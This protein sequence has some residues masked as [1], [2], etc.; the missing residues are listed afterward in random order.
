MSRSC[1][2]LDQLGPSRPAGAIAAC[3]RSG[4]MRGSHERS[5][6]FRC[7]LAYP[8]PR[9]FP[10]SDDAVLGA[11]NLLEALGSQCS[12][13]TVFAGNAGNWTTHR[14]GSRLRLCGWRRRGG[15][16]SCRG[17]SPLS[18]LS[19]AP[20]W[21]DF[22]DD[23]YAGGVRPEV[24]VLATAIV[25]QARHEEVKTIVWPL[26]ILDSDHERVAAASAPRSLG[27]S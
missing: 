22:L 9:H 26:G 23:Q 13:V 25:E 8:N 6:V 14:L 10:S 2:P 16:S 27:A 5:G 12:V 18:W 4:A 1:D 20:I 7:S 24:D 3:G 15:T 21:L 17:P 19:C 11:G